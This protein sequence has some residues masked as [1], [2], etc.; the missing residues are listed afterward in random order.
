MTK[1]TKATLSTVAATLLTGIAF[2]QAGT[3]FGLESISTMQDAQSKRASSSDPDWKNGNADARPIPP[4]ETLVL[5]ELEGPGTVNHIWNTIA[6]SERGYSRLLVLRMYWDGEEKPSVEC[7]I[8]DFFGIGHGID[9]PFV[10]LPVKVSSEGRGRNC[11]WPMPFAKS[12]RITVTNEGK[13]PTN[14]FYYYI[15]WQKLPQL[16]PNTAYFHAMYRQEFPTVSGQNYLLAD[17]EGRGQ[18]VG[19]VLSVRQRTASW[20]GEGDD[21][22]YIDGEKEPSLR[23][24]GSEDY[25]C[26]GWGFRQ[27]D[28]PFY[29][30]PLV[31]GYDAGDH[32]SVYRWHITDPVRFT[33]SLRVEIEHKGVTF[34]PDNTVKSG[35]EERTD[36]FSSVAYWYQ[37]EPHKPWP[38]PPAGYARMYYDYSK[39]VE[40]E[41]LIPKATA[42][43]G[44]VVKQDLGNSS[45]GAQLFWQAPSEGQTLSLPV[46][47]GEAGKYELVLFFTTSFDYGTY[48]ILLDDKPLGDPVDFYTAN[49]EQTERYHPSQNLDAGTHTLTFK[50]VGKNGASKGYFFGFDGLLLNK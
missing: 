8:G 7:P 47:V 39:I 24:T 46:E 9:K 20:W 42:S 27:Q 13:K 25:Y 35:F 31:E 6:S 37:A 26:D 49:I 38:A 21:F 23:G 10:S 5:A 50:N 33:K 34:N 16:P 36:D 43:Q 12:A 41:A 17:I 18:Y 40:G 1:L 2:G 29:G 32:T 44:P 15:D 3:G 22:F 4:G 45:G 14:A 28:G 48:Q 11:Y 30:A 19:T